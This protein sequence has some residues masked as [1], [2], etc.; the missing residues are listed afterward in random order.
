MIKNKT[1]AQIAEWAVAIAIAFAAFLLIT[2]FLVVF[3]K[4]FGPSMVP[5]FENGDRVVVSPAVYLF[6]KPKLGDVIVFSVDRKGKKEE[7]IKR[8]VG[9][10]GDTVDYY[11]Q[12]VYINEEP[13]LDIASGTYDYGCG[14]ISYPFVVP[15]GKYFVMGDNKILSEDSR[16]TEIGLV[17]RGKIKGKVVF[18][19]YPFDKVGTI[20]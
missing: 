3:S 17:P 16:Y 15:E 4:V 11:D 1:A 9:M 13:V 6:S 7:L 10:P 2:N 12:C 18:R 20:D 8:I 5:T 19:F 14:D